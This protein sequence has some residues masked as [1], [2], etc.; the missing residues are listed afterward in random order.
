MFPHAPSHEFH[1]SFGHI[2]LSTR[3]HSPQ[4]SPPAATAEPECS[5]VQFA[6]CHGGRP[7]SCSTRTLEITLEDP[8]CVLP[9]DLHAFV[10]SPRTGV[11]QPLLQFDALVSRLVA[12]LAGGNCTGQEVIALLKDMLREVRALLKEM[13]AEL[14]GSYHSLEEWEEDLVA[15]LRD[16]RDI[17]KNRVGSLEEVVRGVRLLRPA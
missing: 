10:Y 15:A 2:A 16:V 3:T 8:K 13:P 4:N 14:Q 9:L 11:P 7:R 1:N 12:A 6:S 17:L 5:Q